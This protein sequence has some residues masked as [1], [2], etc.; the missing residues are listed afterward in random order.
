MEHI[1]LHEIEVHLPAVWSW[2]AGVAVLALVAMG[3]Q[4]TAL[5]AL[6]KH[7]MSRQSEIIDKLIALETM[8]KHPDD[9]QFGT[10]GTNEMVTALTEECRK[11]CQR[12]REVANSIDNLTA[13][14]RYDIKHRTGVNPPPN[15][16][17]R[18]L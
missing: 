18:D 17:L 14:I 6:L 1:P 15:G 9:F 7:G 8:H 3:A 13:L 16:T 2:G 12:N 11:T 4:L 10:K 5:H